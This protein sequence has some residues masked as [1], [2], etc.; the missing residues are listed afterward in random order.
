MLLISTVALGQIFPLIKIIGLVAIVYVLLNFGKEHFRGY[1]DIVFFLIAF[2]LFNIVSYVWT[3]DEVLWITDLINL[4]SVSFNF[5]LLVTLAAKANNQV[6]SII[7]GWIT[8]VLLTFPIAFWELSTNLHL[9]SLYADRDVYIRGDISIQKRF[10]AGTFGNLNNY[11]TLL[12]VAL[13]FVASLIFA[14]IKLFARISIFTVVLGIIYIILMNASRGGVLSLAATGFI[15]FCFY[16]KY[17]RTSFW[18]VLI[19]I[20][21]VVLSL[22]YFDSAILQFEQRLIAKGNILSD[23]GRQNMIEYGF[24]IFLNNPLGIGVGNIAHHYSRYPTGG[25]LIPHNL[26][27]EFLLYGGAIFFT[28]FIVW[29]VKIFLR[30]FRS[31]S[32]VVRFIF[33]ASA[34]SLIPASIINSGYFLLPYIWLLFAS[35]YVISNTKINDDRLF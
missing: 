13:P 14:K 33:Q 6:R 1:R 17:L 7:Y 2:I 21:M 26:L 27:M 5:M 29:L 23:F 12:C 30:G 10:S 18:G 34:L 16:W 4:T 35:F 31:N 25:L 20:C 32:K 22:Y 8:L 28:I 15:F 9:S 11:T 24:D 19:A 3:S